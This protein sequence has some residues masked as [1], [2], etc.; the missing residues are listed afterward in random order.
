M[1]KLIMSFVLCMAVVV[2][3]SSVTNAA[4][5]YDNRKEADKSNI[6]YTD[7]SGNTKVI[8]L[9]TVAVLPVLS[10]IDPLPNGV[11]AGVVEI[12][13]KNI[14]YP[15]FAPVPEGKVIDAVQQVNLEQEVTK[16]GLTPALLNKVQKLTGADIVVAVH[17][18]K[19]QETFLGTQSTD[20]ANLD[21]KMDVVAVYSWGKKPVEMR[22][23][24]RSQTEYA[25]VSKNSYAA[26]EVPRELDRAMDNVL[27]FEKPKTKK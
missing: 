3:I 4:V 24:S 18:K 11:Y 19:I 8:E 25:T 26:E 16:N 6:T 27:K 15:K 17:L 10:D 9:P 14:S 7:K 21:F 20:Y 5:I 22:I 12:L 23:S 2:G 13:E 1:K